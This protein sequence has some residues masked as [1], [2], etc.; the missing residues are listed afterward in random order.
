MT[1]GGYLTQ[2][3][4]N[5]VF[6][7]D[8]LSCNA[9][10]FPVIDYQ[11]QWNDGTSDQYADGQSLTIINNGL[12]NYTCIAINDIGSAAIDNIVGTAGKLSTTYRTHWTNK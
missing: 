7:N 2:A 10:G 12:I 9:I 4:E 11:W 5:Y 6:M 8:T 1:I 3:D